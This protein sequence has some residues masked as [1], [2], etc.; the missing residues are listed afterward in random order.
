MAARYKNCLGYDKRDC[1][2][3]EKALE[4]YNEEDIPETYMEET[5]EWDDVSMEIL[6]YLQDNVKAMVV[7]IL[8]QRLGL[9]DVIQLIS[10][11]AKKKIII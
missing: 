1:Q 5:T 2:Y 9:F 4:I 10:V 11:H 8:D 3:P 7:P 6:Y